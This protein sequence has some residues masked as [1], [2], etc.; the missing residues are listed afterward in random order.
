MIE[1]MN[2]QHR[3][4]VESIKQILPDIQEFKISIES[5]CSH[6]NQSEDRIP[7]L[8]DRI[9]VNDNEKKDFLKI[10]RN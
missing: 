10:P 3:K 1:N 8:E 9:A 4:E 6:L 2:A 5:I 7:D